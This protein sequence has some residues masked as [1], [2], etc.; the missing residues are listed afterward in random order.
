MSGRVRPLSPDVIVT[1]TE[2]DAVIDAGLQDRIGAAWDRERS[3]RPELYDGS[4]FACDEVHDLGGTVARLIGH[5]VPYSWYVV[6]RADADIAKA[7]QL[8]VLGVSA[9]LRCADGIVV[10]RRA[11]T[12]NDSG[13][14]ELVPSGAV[15][16]GVVTGERVDVHAAVLGELHEELALSRPELDAPPSA[17]ALVDDDDALLFE[18]GFR[19]S[20]GRSFADIERAQAA[21]PAREHDQLRLLTRQSARIVDAPDFSATSVA[22][23]AAAG[24]P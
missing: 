14:W 20:T 16:A 15:D 19:M 12:T 22:L 24:L 13:L 3:R 4:L 5:F 8:R 6:A 18:V 7:L 11:S 9:I 1:M 17:F 23:L 2:T 21:L 10:G